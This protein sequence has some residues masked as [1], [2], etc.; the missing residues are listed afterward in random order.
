M[1][2]FPDLFAYVLVVVIYFTV[3]FFVSLSFYASLIYLFT[4][5]RM[6]FLAVLGGLIGFMLF[7]L[8]TTLFISLGIL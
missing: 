4:V 1:N 8:W 7:F 3:L 2:H 5:K 6:R